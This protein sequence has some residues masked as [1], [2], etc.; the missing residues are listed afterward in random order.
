MGHE[1]TIRP[2]VE[3]DLTDILALIVAV[4]DHAGEHS[5][6]TESVGPVWDAVQGNPH[7]HLFVAEENDTIL[8]TFSLIIIQQLAHGGSRVAVIEDVAVHASAQGRGIGT[9]MMTYAATFAREQGCVKLMLSSGKG[10]TQA[11]AFYE[12]NGYRQHGISFYLD[13]G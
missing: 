7:H 4:L 5:L 10:R 3:A 12:K 1:L 11:H 2:A 9:Q 8:G 6:T 13:L